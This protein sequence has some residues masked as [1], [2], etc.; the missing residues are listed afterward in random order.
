MISCKII[1]SLEKVFHNTDI[2]A[3]EQ[4]ERI[5]ALKGERL[6][7]Q[8]AFVS[9]KAVN[10]QVRVP[11]KL[12]GALAEYATVRNISSVSVLHPVNPTAYDEEYLST[13]P[14]LYPDVLTPLHYGSCI[15]PRYK[16]A[17]AVFID[18]EI[19]KDMPAGESTITVNLSL[20]TESVS[21]SLTVEVIDAVMPDFPIYCTQWFHSDCLASYYNVKVWSK[22][23]WEIVENFARVAVKNGINLLLTPVFT[24]PLDTAVGGERPT[25]QLVGVTVTNGEYS[26]DFKLLDKWI[27]MCNRVGVKYLEIAHFF[28]QWGAHHA[29]KIMATVDGEYKRIFGWDTEATGEEYTRFLRTFVPALLSHLKQRGDDKRCFFHVSDEPGADH[30]D[31]YLAAK[32]IVAPMLEGYPIMDALSKYEFYERGIVDLPIPANNHIKPFIENDVKPLWTYYCCG[33]SVAVSN[34]FVAMPSW[35]NRSIGLQMYKYDIRG[36]L[37][38]GYNFYY[39]FHSADLINPYCE[40]DG[41]EWISAGDAF[42]VYPA[43]DGTALESMR[44]IVFADALRDLAVMRLLENYMPKEKIVRAIEDAVGFEISFDK[45]ATSAKQILDARETVNSLLK[46]AIKETSK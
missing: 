39:N 22:R 37:Q 31:S 13:E 41:D 36:F 18:V 10:G 29:P 21:A 40:Q 20:P 32:S 27:R 26:F 2:G 35:R 38:W 16:T 19:P 30:L 28:T 15:I 33:Q 3:L 9:D 17:S 42:S 7:F 25:V 5:S 43:C 46:Q 12:E 24:P 4:L 34:R 1:S 8:M 23:H 6:S 45:C 44:I 11:L 14:G